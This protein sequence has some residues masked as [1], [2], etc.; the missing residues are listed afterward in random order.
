MHH[1]DRN[2]HAALIHAARARKPQAEYVRVAQYRARQ[3]EDR[4]WAA[5]WFAFTFWT[6]LAVTGLAMAYVP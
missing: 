2:A 6:A 3:R 1:S 4:L 5:G